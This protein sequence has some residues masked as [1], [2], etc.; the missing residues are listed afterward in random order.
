MTEPFAVHYAVVGEV[1]PYALEWVPAGEKFRT[2]GRMLGDGLQESAAT[3]TRQYWQLHVHARELIVPLGTV[4]PAD[5]V[6]N[7]AESNGN[8]ASFL[9]VQ[10]EVSLSNNRDAMYQMDIGAG[11]DTTLD[12][13]NRIKSVQ[14][15]V[16]V[17]GSAP[18]IP[19]V[20][21]E[22]P[23]NFATAVTISWCCVQGPLAATR[24]SYSQLFLLEGQESA[25][26]PVVDGARELELFTGSVDVNNAA[27]GFGAGDQASF[28]LELD[29]PVFPRI[30]PGALP[31]MLGVGDLNLL[32]TQFH[33]LRTIIPGQA[34]VIVFK[35]AGLSDQRLVNFVQVL[36]F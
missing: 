20:L 30:E 36:H 24:P 34:N 29:S 25:V 7:L 4:I 28:A 33:T 16:P 15:L 8:H 26:M 3:P 21:A 14:V 23:R 5:K 10:V 11:L 13:G 1:N 12:F 18:R 17:P 2:K 32:A 31:P 9:K 22:N 27:T 19:T 6:L 35:S